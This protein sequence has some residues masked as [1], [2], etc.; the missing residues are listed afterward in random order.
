MP[1]F[2]ELELE[3][4]LYGVKASLNHYLASRPGVAVQSLP[5]LIDF[6][7]D[8]ADTVMPFFQQEFLEMALEA[9]DMGDQHYQFLVAELQR[10]SRTEGIDR[11]IQEH[12]LDAIIAPTEGSPS[13]VIDLLSGDHL[14]PYGCSSPPA[15]AGYPHI[16]VPAG[17]VQGLPVGLSFFSTAYT[18]TT[19]L[20]LAHAFEQAIQIRQP[21]QFLATITG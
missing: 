4:F 19:L 12:H 15:V 2:G 3:L 13:F 6:N 7:R 21:P 8:H 9:G 1:F 16:T 17:Y 20:G 10:L 5:E 14:E 18:E 11:A